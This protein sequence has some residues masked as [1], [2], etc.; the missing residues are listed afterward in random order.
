MVAGE[1]QTKNRPPTPPGLAGVGWPISP[2]EV[3]RVRPDLGVGPRVRFVGVRRGRGLFS[4]T[5]RLQPLNQPWRE[6]DNTTGCPIF[7]NRRCELGLRVCHGARNCITPGP[8]AAGQVP[9][10]RTRTMDSEEPTQSHHRPIDASE[11][12]C[13]YSG[14]VLLAQTQGLSGSLMTGHRHQILLYQC[15]ARGKV[16]AW[17]AEDGTVGPYCLRTPGSFR[18]CPNFARRAGLPRN[19]NVSRYRPTWHLGSDVVILIENQQST[20]TLLA[21]RPG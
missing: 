10:T 5:A 15:R 7:N 18:L 20:Y 19:R 16:T 4:V 11:K 14:S 21:L 13:P 2:Y 9:L 6:N 8:V 3:R 17:C 12:E 1:V